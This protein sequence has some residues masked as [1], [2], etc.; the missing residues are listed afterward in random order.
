MCVCV[1]VCVCVRAC[2]SVCV[3]AQVCVCV[4][5][6]VCAYVCVYARAHM[7]VRVGVCQCVHVCGPAFSTIGL[8]SATSQHSN[9]FKNSKIG[10]AWIQFL[11]GSKHISSRL[12]HS[13]VM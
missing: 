11:Y 9:N 1:R 10:S 7:C 12:T 6:C 8:E 2:A 13:K 4:S 3:C 5:V